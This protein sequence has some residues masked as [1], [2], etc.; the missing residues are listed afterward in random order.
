MSRVFE[1][2][3]VRR[4][5]ANIDAKVVPILEE[6]NA[7]LPELT[8]IDRNL[9]TTVTLPMAASYSV[10]TSTLTE[11]LAGAAQCFRDM[12]EALEGSAKDMEDT[13]DACAKAFGN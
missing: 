13:D 4:L 12:R 8:N 9:Y 10:A 3:F 1:P 7:L 2:E 6:T 11:S 5:G